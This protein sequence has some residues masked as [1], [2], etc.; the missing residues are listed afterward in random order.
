MPGEKRKAVSALHCPRYCA[1]TQHHQ[2]NSERKSVMSN[3]KVS[4]IHAFGVEVPE[5]MSP[6]ELIERLLNEGEVELEKELDEEPRQS[7]PQSEAD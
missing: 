7:E 3:N 4:G 2:S 1:D 5:D 6:K